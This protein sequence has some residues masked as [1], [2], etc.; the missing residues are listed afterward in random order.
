MPHNATPNTV[1]SPMTPLDATLHSTNENDL[2]IRRS[3]DRTPPGSLE[4]APVQAAG[5]CKKVRECRRCRVETGNFGTRISK[6][7]EILQPYCRP[8]MVAYHKEWRAGAGA[9]KFAAK[10]AKSKARYPERV[11]AA[12]KVQG[13]IRSGRLVRGACVL[14]SEACR[15]AIEGHHDD[16]SLPLEVRWVCRAHHRQLDRERRVIDG[17]TGRGEAVC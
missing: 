12:R 9:E 8:C 7:R 4:L 14:A 2:L 13:A 5:V 15:G 11:R 10:Q 3:W 6:G 16:Y 17:L 1:T